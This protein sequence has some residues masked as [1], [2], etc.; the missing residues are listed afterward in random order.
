MNYIYISHRHPFYSQT[1][2]FDLSFFNR[3]T[4]AY[5][6]RNMLLRATRFAT[7][8]NRQKFIDRYIQRMVPKAQQH[9]TLCLFGASKVNTGSTAIKGCISS[10]IEYL[11][12]RIN[13][14]C[15][16]YMTVNEAYTSQLCSVCEHKMPKRVSKH[17]NQFC[18]VC[19]IAWNSDHNAALYILKVGRQ[20]AVGSR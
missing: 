6:D 10:P 18:R 19:K 20:L 12:H 4:E 11:K 16:N 17:N 5:A 9:E 1:V 2:E 3:E 14:Y 13:V 7:Y 8:V 15:Y